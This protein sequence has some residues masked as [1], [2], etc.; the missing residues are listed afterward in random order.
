MTGF[1]EVLDENTSLRRRRAEDAATIR[2]YEQRLRESD[3]RHAADAVT[4][5]EQAERLDEQEQLIRQQAERIAELEA[6]VEALVQSQEAFA[7][8]FEL[9]QKKREI[10]KAERFIAD[11]S[12]GKLFDDENVRLPPR[13]PALQSSEE[14]EAEA[15]VGA[16]ADRRRRSRA[17][18]GH[19]RRGRRKLADVD[20]P[21]RTVTVPVGDANCP[22]CGDGLA[23]TGSTTS[24]RVGWVPGRFQILVV[25]REQCAC[26]NHPEGGSYAAPE[27]F[28]LPGALCDDAMLAQVVV[29]KYEDHLPLNRQSKRMARRGLPIGTN[30]LSSWLAKGFSCVKS[31]VK[32]LQKEVVVGQLV[33]SDDTGHPVQDKGD[34]TLRN[35]RLW[36]FTDQRQAFYVFSPN[37]KGDHPKNVLEGLG[38]KGGTLVADG[39]SEYNL[40]ESK[41]KLRRGGCWS[42]LRRYFTTAAVLEPQA[43]VVLPTIQDLF[44]IERELA[45]LEPDARLAARRERSAPLVDGLYQFIEDLGPSLRP[46]SLL[47]QACGYALSQ[48]S[49]M[50]LFLED[51]AVP[52]HNNLSELL[53]RQ[54]VVGRKNWMFSRSEGGAIAA[55]GW[56]SLIA[57]AKLQGLVPLEYLYDL[58]QRLPS[59]PSQRVHELTPLNWRRAVEE[60]RLKP[61]PVGQF[62]M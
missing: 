54:H 2:A 44:L 8:A 25:E 49:R 38:F 45:S 9:L 27:P 62:L 39:G 24:H 29:D 18:G 32:A 33:L 11:A 59:Y 15:N 7:Q 12:Q 43:K 46:T 22:T 23:V 31:V 60:G 50:R 10:A 58:F 36:A 57:S 37:K 13:D 35:G 5:R 53:L 14:A 52:L 26:P 48:Q 34:G 56:L 41:L 21:K 1:A 51:G 28:L 17:Q 40:A 61:V 30:V 42:H 55:A 4:I 16:P 19:P 20:L 47:A 6:K 3:E